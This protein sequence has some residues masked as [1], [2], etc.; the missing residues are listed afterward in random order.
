MG[1]LVYLGIGALELDWGKNCNVCNHSQLFQVADL[2]KIP[3]YYADDVVEMKTCFSKPLKVVQRRMDLLGYSY[4][5]LRGLYK[6]Y[7]AC[8]PSYYEPME[9]DYDDT[10][11]INYLL[12]YIVSESIRNLT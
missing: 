8:Y 3:Y 12:E 9:L 7:I 1:S 2:K 11:K 10:L 4:D 6:G 5:N